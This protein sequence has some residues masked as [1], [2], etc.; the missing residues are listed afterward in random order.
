MGK[1]MTFWTILRSH[2]YL[3]VIAVFLLWM[4][5]MDENNWIMRIRHKSEIATLNSEIERYRTQFN[6]DT[7]RLEE[8]TEN[9]EALEKVAREKYFMKRPDE[10]VFVFD[11]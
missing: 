3:T 5:F 7:E 10:D 11:K 2:K 4:S 1:L 6:E 9:P 8:L